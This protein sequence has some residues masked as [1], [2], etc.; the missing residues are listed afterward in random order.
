MEIVNLYRYER[1][2][3]G[4]TVSPIQPETDCTVMYR[5]IADEGKVLTK[6]GQNFTVCVDVE[7]IDGWREVQDKTDQALERILAGQ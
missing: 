5:L 1:D 2:G 6:D 4:I 3:G 7:E